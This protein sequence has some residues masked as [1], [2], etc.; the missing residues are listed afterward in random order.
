M[1]GGSSE[2]ALLLVFLLWCRV[3]RWLDTLNAL[4]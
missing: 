4:T 1:G 3:S 2:A